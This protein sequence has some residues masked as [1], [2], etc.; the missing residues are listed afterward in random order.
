MSKVCLFLFATTVFAVAAFADSSVEVLYVAETRG[1]RTVEI[2]AFQSNT[3]KIARS[4]SLPVQG[5]VA[6][7]TASLTN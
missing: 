5:K 7:A 3:G 2:Y 4:S 1:G 6:V